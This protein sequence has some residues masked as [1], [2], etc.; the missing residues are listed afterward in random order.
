MSVRQRRWAKA[1]PMSSYRVGFSPPPRSPP[2]RPRLD[3]AHEP[4]AIDAPVVER[5]RRRADH[6]GLAPVDDDAD[7]VQMIEQRTAVL[8]SAAHAQRQLAAAALGL[9]RR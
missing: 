4:E 2:L 5:R 7:R 8:A 3:F 1:H 6:V 9:A